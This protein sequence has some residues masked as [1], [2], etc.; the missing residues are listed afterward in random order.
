LEWDTGLLIA[1]ITSGAIPPFGIWFGEVVWAGDHLLPPGGASAD[2]GLDHAIGHAVTQHAGDIVPWNLVGGITADFQG[3]GSLSNGVGHGY[4]AGQSWIRTATDATHL[5]G[6]Y[7][8]VI[9]E[10]LH[11]DTKGLLHPNALGHQDY[12]A[13]IFDHLKTLLPAPPAPP[14]NFAAADTNSTSNTAA[15][16]AGTTTVSSRHGAHGWLTGCTSSNTSLCP[17][18][19]DH[20]V[21]QIVAAVPSTTAVRGAGLTV[22]GAPVDCNAGTGLPNG[23]TCQQALLDSGKVYKWS[24][25]LANDG[26]YEL[27]A[28]V[29]AEDD[30]VGTTTHEVKVDLHDPS[31]PTVSLPTNPG[32]VNGWYRNAVTVTF[33]V[34]SLQGVGVDGISYQLD[35]GQP[36]MVH[37]LGQLPAGSAPDLAQVTVS[38]DG[39][40]T[41][42]YRTVDV[43]GRTS[44]PVTTSFKIDG[45]APAVS[46]GSADGA[47][48]AS[49][50]QVSCSAT[51]AL[52]GLADTSDATVTLSTS[53]AAETETAN[54]ATSSHSVCD[55]AGNC[56]TA[57]P[58]TGNKVDE[59]APSISVTTPSATTY[60]LHQ[61]VTAVYGCTDGGSGTASCTGSSPNGQAVD[62]NSNGTKTFSVHAVDNVGNASDKSVTY[63]VGY[64]VHPLYDETKSH[65]A[66]SVVPVKLQLW[67]AAGVNLSSAG[68]TVNSIGL[69]KVDNSA[70]STVDN[71][72][73]AT[74]DTNF[75][76]DASLG[77]YIFNLKTT[78]LTTGTWA[79]RFTTSGDGVTHTVQFDIR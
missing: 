21:T 39:T 73:A 23:V 32:P 8:P 78:G 48:H 33:D 4:C 18:S 6:P 60:V 45:T 56:A 15:N 5:Q 1:A 54:A 55:V 71:A 74:A 51:D 44:A 24:L 67:D 26:T 35:G 34:A 42:V 40:H 9:S 76:Y 64:A 63:Q 49:D 61:P 58:V 70:S 47:W 20:A 19:S 13:H 46:C 66:G 53:V 41:L 2:H 14:I 37:A 59:K 43:G 50:V 77:G 69:V 12:A 28:S 3:S 30:T 52:S 57:G 17:S 72:S 79:L 22:N 65:K 10:L 25:Q 36:A 62:T 75:R 16:P 31:G 29:T 11:T 68:I 27:A 38:G 7:T